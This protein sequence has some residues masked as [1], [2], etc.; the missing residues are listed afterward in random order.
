MKELP[1]QDV[2]ERDGGHRPEG[3]DQQ[4]F[5]EPV[6]PAEET[7]RESAFP[8]GR[9]RH[10]GRPPAVDRGSARAPGLGRPA[11]LAPATA[12]KASRRSFPTTPS[13]FWSTGATSSW[14]GRR[15]S[16]LS[17]V[18]ASPFDRMASIASASPWRANVR[19]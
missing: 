15:C 13:Y 18:T 6:D 9:R 11:H 4:V 10:S 7:G 14:N 12:R 5:L 16:A 17:R 19:W 8:G 1:V 2:R 3:D